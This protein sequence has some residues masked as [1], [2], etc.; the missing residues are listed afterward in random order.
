MANIKK[1]A[2]TEGIAINDVYNRTEMTFGLGFKV[3]QGADYKI[4]SNARNIDIIIEKI[5]SFRTKL[6][7]GK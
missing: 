3:A 2:E 7:A 5:H 1:H 4:K 6:I